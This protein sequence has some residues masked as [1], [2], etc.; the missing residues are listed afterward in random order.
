VSQFRPLSNPTS[1][2]RHGSFPKRYTMEYDKDWFDIASCLIQNGTWQLYLKNPLFLKI[3]EN[4][5]SLSEF[6]Q[7]P[8]TWLKKRP[9]K[10]DD[11]IHIQDVLLESEDI[12]AIQ[13]MMTEQLMGY[14]YNDDYDTRVYDPQWC[15]GQRELIP[16]QHHEPFDLAWLPL[17]D[18]YLTLDWQPEMSLVGKITDVTIS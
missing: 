14:L 7:S 12:F 11:W 2:K 3:A 5:K 16:I 10:W 15:Q 18:V 17:D 1:N 8:K 9:G 4:K 6:M 13:K